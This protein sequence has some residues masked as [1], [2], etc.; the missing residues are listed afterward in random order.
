[1][2]YYGTLC[3]NHYRNAVVVLYMF[4]NDDILS[5]ENLVTHVEE[6]TKYVSETCFFALVSNKTDIQSD[7][8]PE[9]LI[10]DKCTA[11]ACDKIYYISAKTGSGIDQLMNDLFT[12]V[13]KHAEGRI[14]EPAMSP[15]M[16]LPHDC[17]FESQSKRKC[18][19]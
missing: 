17:H 2:E 14:V 8:I 1:M 18:C 10:E 19:N 4:A 13:T 5:L 12:I 9:G 16:T 6:A 7:E 15:A 11:F 3:H